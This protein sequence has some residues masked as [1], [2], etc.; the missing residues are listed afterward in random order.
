MSATRRR[1]N[2]STPR[3]EYVST[4]EVRDDAVYLTPSQ[5]ELMQV[6]IDYTL[7][8]PP[9]DESVPDDASIYDEEIPPD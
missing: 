7:D 2:R 5:G 9:P 6:R 8:E 1:R 4:P 3:G